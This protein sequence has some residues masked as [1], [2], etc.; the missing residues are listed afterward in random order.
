[1]QGRSL[2]RAFRSSTAPTTSVSTSTGSA[3]RASRWMLAVLSIAL[4]RRG[5][6]QPTNS[7]SSSPS[8]RLSPSQGG[9]FRVYERRGH[10][11]VR[12]AHGSLRSGCRLPDS[13]RHWATSRR[14]QST[15]L[16]QAG[17]GSDKSR[18]VVFPLVSSA[19][20]STRRQRATVRTSTPRT[21]KN[22]YR[23]VRPYGLF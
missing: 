19:R 17:S 10:G 20:T 6:A 12:G 18:V 2:S 11:F 13:L 7:S 15:A 16:S 8:Q 21:M 1:M 23:P 14:S 3:R 5:R 4:V 22:R 9:L